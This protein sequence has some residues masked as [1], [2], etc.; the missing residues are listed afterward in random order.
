MVCQIWSEEII[1]EQWEDGLI[2]LVHKKRDKF[3]LN[4]FRVITLLIRDVQ[5]S[6]IYFIN[7]SNHIWKLFL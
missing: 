2:Y 5:V 3:K 1:P 6:L 4:N 7:F